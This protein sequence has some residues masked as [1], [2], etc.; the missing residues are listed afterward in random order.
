MDSEQILLKLFKQQHY[1][2]TRY[3][4]QKIVMLFSTIACACGT[5]S[6][7]LFYSGM[8][9]IYVFAGAVICSGVAMLLARLKVVSFNTAC[10]SFILYACFILVPIFWYL[11]GITGSAPYVSIAVLV[12]ILSMF[13]GKLLKRLIY[14]YL[15]M[16]LVL[17][18]Y[19]AVVEIP[20]A[21]DLPSLIYTVVAYILAVIL[22]F[23]YMLS[24]QKKIEQ[25]S[26]QFLRSSFRDDLTRLFNRKVLDII[27]QYEEKLYK[28]NKSDYILVMFDVDKFKQMNDE[29]G[30]VFGDIILRNVAKC[31][32]DRV[33]S[34]DFVV[35]YGG[36]EFLVVQTN[37]T[38]KSVQLFIDRI[39]EAM[40]ASCYMEIKVSA[41]YGI[42][43]RSECETPQEVLAL[44]DKR[45]YEK[46]EA[47]QNKN[48]D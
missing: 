23:S 14:P 21:A 22:I 41:S 32:N 46:K 27:L 36:D 19:S 2:E 43:A 38:D 42:A 44:A 25:M 16:L 31:I 30:H 45:L 9:D 3:K 4:M 1:D 28:E 13:T 5:A 17:A 7:I 20:V 8:L 26:D 29:H 33:R 12:A 39:E 48:E 6:M 24:K 18:I 15:G 37:A 47:R 35:R 40:E 11:T 10:L 34:S